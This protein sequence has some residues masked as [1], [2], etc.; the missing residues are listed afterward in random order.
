MKKL[1]I[2]LLSL[3]LALLLFA[4]CGGNS[5][6]PAYAP[7]TYQTTQAPQVND[8]DSYTQAPAQTIAPA[9]SIVGTW[10]CS[11]YGFDVGAM[12]LYS[13]GK[14]EISMDHVYTGTYRKSGSTYEFE[15]TGGKSS[16]SAAL[17][18]E[19]NRS[20]KITADL[21]SDDTVTLHLKAKSGYI[22]YG[23]E[24]ATFR[25]Y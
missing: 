10:T 7:E 5:S 3:C 20:C 9:P 25:R 17:S 16:V 4:G 15:I 21:N 14:M 6:T 22:Y 18:K 11:D 1:L 23:K 24:S 19:K 8:Y 2:A 12:T 13:D